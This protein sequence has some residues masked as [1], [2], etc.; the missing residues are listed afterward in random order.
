MNREQFLQYREE[1]V[2]EAARDKL[3]QHVYSG[4]SN[5]IME[6]ID[7]ERIRSL[8]NDPQYDTKEDMLQVVRDEVGEITGEH[9]TQAQAQALNEEVVFRELHEDKE[10]GFLPWKEVYIGG[11]N[12]PGTGTGTYSGNH[13]SKVAYVEGDVHVGIESEEEQNYTVNGETR[14]ITGDW[15][16]VETIT[17]EVEP[18]EN[19]DQIQMVNGTVEGFKSV[20]AEFD[21]NLE[22][23]EDIGFD[24]AL[25]RVNSML[26]SMTTG[27]SLAGFDDVYQTA[28]QASNSLTALRDD[29]DWENFMLA[30]E[31]S[32][33]HAHQ[34]ITGEEENR[35]TD[36]DATITMGTPSHPELLKTTDE[37]R[38]NIQTNSN[39]QDAETIKQEALN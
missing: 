39:F 9:S 32:V 31:V 15:H 21:P 3:D 28:E 25:E 29:Q 34:S 23:N 4:D 17:G 36:G 14:D 7:I 22:E 16:H 19:F 24:T 12:N 37:I 27:H 10:N 1:Q 11:F 8:W 33:D 18:P 26:L 20:L 2:Y 35:G 38:A 6:H 30:N 5:D 13:G